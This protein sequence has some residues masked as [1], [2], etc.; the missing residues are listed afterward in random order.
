MQRGE[1][2]GQQRAAQ[3]TLAHPVSAQ[4]SLIRMLGSSLLAPGVGSPISFQVVLTPSWTP[5]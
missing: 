3:D 1:R 2:L 5:P 4:P